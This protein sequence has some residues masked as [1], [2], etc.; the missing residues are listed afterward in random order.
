LRLPLR[1]LAGKV[2]LLVRATPRAARD[3]IAGLV[4]DAAGEPWLAV[5]VRA[6]AEGGKA[7]QAVL[8]VLAA[9]LELRQAQLELSSGTGAR[10]KRIAVAAPPG[11]V[12]ARLRQLLDMP[13]GG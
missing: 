12:E 7:N 2:E 13:R 4:L 1:R 8:R 9:A 10:A 6:P 5:R 3:E 11:E